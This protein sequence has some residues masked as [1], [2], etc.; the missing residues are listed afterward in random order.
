M[1]V[2]IDDM[3]VKSTVVKDHQQHFVEMFDII[4]KYK[5]KFNPIKCTFG[6]NSGQLLGYMVN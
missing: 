5:M 2:Y 4:R 6:V 3:L 1:D